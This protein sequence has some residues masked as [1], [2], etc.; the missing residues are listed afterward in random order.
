MP[1]LILVALVLAAAAYRAEL[2]QRFEVISLSITRLLLIVSG[3]LLPIVFA[4][5]L[6]AA[7]QPPA[8]VSAV[9]TRSAIT[10]TPPAGRRRLDR[11]RHLR[12]NAP[13]DTWATFRDR[14][15][16][17]SSAF[18]WRAARLRSATQES[19]GSRCT[20]CRVRR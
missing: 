1:A 2:D 6:T 5:A 3:S 10:T 7:P 8:P 11:R 20:G 15:G 14:A 13:H 4:R 17:S 18:G 9:S 19:C 16:V 12:R